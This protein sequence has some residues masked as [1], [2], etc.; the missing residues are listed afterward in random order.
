ME[1]KRPF[2]DRFAEAA[3]RL[4]TQIHLRT[5]RDAFATI[6]PLYILAG[7]AVL[8]NNVIFNHLLSGGALDFTTYWGNMIINGTLSI[9]GLMIAPTIGYYLSKNRGFEK[10]YIAAIISLA[11]MI[12]MMPGTVEAVP[13]GAE[14]AVSL[15]G[16]L[17]YSNLGANSMFAG[18][19]IGLCATELFIRISRIERLQI[20]LGDEVPQAVSDSFN[21][22]IPVIIVISGFAVISA[23]LSVGF[24][25]DLIKLISTLI[26][27]PLKNVGTSLGGCLVLYT[28]GNLL[29]TQ[30]IHQSVIYG[31]ILEPLLIVNM[32]E[33][34]AAYAAGDPIPNILNVA[35][36]I[37]IGYI[38]TAIGFMS[39]CVVQIPWTTPPLLSGF[40]AT[41]G[42][43]KAVIVQALILAL[44]VL[45]YLP[46]MKASETVQK[47][48]ME[49]ED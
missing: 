46:F 22:L 47:K 30:G 18:I 4:G 32:T 45:I 7:L 9:A 49:S 16:M 39:P 19:I 10:P 35:M 6:M 31:S 29:F 14:D 8:F 38:A 24:H 23:A 2:M 15:T 21:V 42:D 40:L 27:T 37:T 44:G 33:N 1:E 12:V 5:L 41:G 3:A 34:M 26:Q 43:F 13:V 20:N 28:L 11:T 17:A 48:L 36:G 25:T